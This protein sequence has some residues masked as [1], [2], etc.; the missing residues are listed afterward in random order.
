MSLFN[1]GN[2]ALGNQLISL[3]IKTDDATEVIEVDDIPFVI[4][5]DNRV[6]IAQADLTYSRATDKTTFT[7][8]NTIFTNAGH[9]IHAYVSETG[10]AQFGCTAEVNINGTT[11]EL[12][13]DWTGSDV[14]IG[15]RFTAL[16]LLFRSSM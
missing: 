2:T 12:D 6:E 13:G 11:G 8:P 5:L 4:Y 3:D 9:E 10:A 15:Y 1:N 14:H 16:T 7:I